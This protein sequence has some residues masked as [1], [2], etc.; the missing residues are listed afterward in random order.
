MKNLA[1]EVG[2]DS[3]YLALIT[4]KVFTYPASKLVRLNNECF[5]IKRAVN[6]EYAVKR[7]FYNELF[8]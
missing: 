8:K 1:S 7:N 6:E 2:S 5:I 3:K 4:E